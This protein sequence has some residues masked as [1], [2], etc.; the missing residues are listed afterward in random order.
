MW[1]RPAADFFQVPNDADLQAA[2]VR[3]REREQDIFGN[4]SWIHTF[5]PGVL[6]TLAPSYHFNRAAFEG[7]GGDR[8]A[9]GND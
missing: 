3:D 6:L 2:G 9:V 4:L 1:V 5:G 8:P 7:L